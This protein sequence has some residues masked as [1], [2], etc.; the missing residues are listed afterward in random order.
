MLW[1][2][3][4]FSSACF[5][6]RK[7]EA[8]IHPGFTRNFFSLTA[9]LDLSVPASPEITCVIDSSTSVEHVAP[10]CSAILHRWWFS[11]GKL[12]GMT[13]VKTIL[14]P[15]NTSFRTVFRTCLTSLSSR[16]SLRPWK[17]KRELR[18][19][20][21]SEPTVSPIELIIW[22]RGEII[23]RQRIIRV[24]AEE[25]SGQW[26]GPPQSH[27]HQFS[28]VTVNYSWS[29][30]SYSSRRKNDS[31][32][33]VSDFPCFLSKPKTDGGNQLIIYQLTKY[34]TWVQK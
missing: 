2:T 11:A 3:G 29:Q 21:I 27:F 8:S 9:H 12:I 32:P 28:A 13:R 20:G 26:P 31:G 14:Q 25:P 4:N 23:P 7:F 17:I 19:R 15:F 1:L 24:H 34:L 33:S 16:S 6:H 22:N 18:N 5:L 10:S 30:N